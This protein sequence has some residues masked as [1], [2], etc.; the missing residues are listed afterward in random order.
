MSTTFGGFPK[1]PADSSRRK[2]TQRQLCMKAQERLSAAFRKW[3]QNRTLL[4]QKRKQLAAAVAA[5]DRGESPDPAYLSI[6]VECLDE[7]CAELFS[8]LLRVA[9]EVDGTRDQWAALQGQGR[10]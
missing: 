9:D 8:E 5:F 3:D 7:L 2:H 10:E 4:H 6:E 1:T